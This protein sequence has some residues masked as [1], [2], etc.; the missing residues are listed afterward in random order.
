MTPEEYSAAK[1]S[2][3]PLLREWQ[4]STGVKRERIAALIYKEFERFIQSKSRSF[5]KSFP[6]HQDDILQ[7]A[8]LGFYRA[9]TKWDESKSEEFPSYAE[10][11]I[12]AELNLL[13]QRYLQGQIRPRG[14]EKPRYAREF[15]AELQ[16]DPTGTP[17]EVCIQNQSINRLYSAIKRLP[18]KRQA[19]IRGKLL[20][21]SLREL[22]LERN[23]SHQAIG[24][25]DRLAVQKLRKIMN[26][27]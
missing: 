20:G 15:F 16:S 5:L 12:K 2:W 7:S 17:E 23:V 26:K 27:D 18:P 10:Y 4:T 22:G 9:L 13:Y 19:I 1:A 14:E 21:K 3:L 11:W 8:R 24:F 6:H 25:S